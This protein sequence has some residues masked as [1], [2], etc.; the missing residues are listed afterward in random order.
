MKVYE[1]LI[2][3]LF[4]LNQSKPSR[5]YDEALFS[6]VEK[7][8]ARAFLENLAEGKID[9]K[10][11]L[12]PTLKIKEEEI[13]N[14]ISSY[15]LAF[16][17]PKL[18]DKGKK[19]LLEK[20]TQDEDEYMSLISKIRAES[21]GLGDLISPKPCP[22]VQI[23][24]QL[25]DERTVLVEYFLGERNSY[26]LF[27]TKR[28]IDFYSLPARRDIEESLKAY[29]K[30]LSAP[31]QGEFL[32][33]PAASRLF[34]EL[35]FPLEKLRPG[36]IENLIIIPDGILYYLP[37]ETLRSAAQKR[38]LVE[39]FNI[40]YAPSASSLLYLLREESGPH[41]QKSLLGVGDPVYP[42][43]GVLATQKPQASSE[44]MRELY[45]GEGFE[46]SPLPY[47]K[48]EISA[49]S[50]YFPKEKKQIYLEKEA[51]EDII[52]KIPLQDYQVIHFACH[53]LLDEKV[54]YRSALVLSQAENSKEDGFLQ[55]REIYSLRIK[56]DLVVLSACQTGKGS[57]EGNEGILG[58][59]SIFFY[60]GAKSVVSSLW[61]IS[62]RSTAAFMDHF[63]GFLS[64]GKDKAQALRLAK[65][66]MI[67]SKFSHPFYWAAFVLTGEPRARL[68]F[69][70]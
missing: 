47:S 12:S 65:L 31:P 13:S 51:S 18:G 52:K 62:D 17:N 69:D 11:G 49:I 33:N 20:L 30:L 42:N 43:R 54:P 58:I 37:F 24:N 55:V 21:P 16:S 25:L 3:F 14:R 29:L 2:D 57:L 22:F 4:R 15:L 66:G 53:G 34:R 10:V 39:D 60:S 23:Q 35:L 5:K 7:A 70:R 26:L 19:S 36:E 67:K 45:L 59:P 46:I 50:R 1:C 38:C 28:D 64:K 6:A 41:P 44:I 63:Y 48:K 40:S 27:V 68:N 9:F 32:G 56:A 8:K 61:K